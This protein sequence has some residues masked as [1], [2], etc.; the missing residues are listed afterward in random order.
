MSV[1]MSQ[2]IFDYATSE[3][4]QDAFIS[5][6]VCWFYNDDENLQRI[7]IDFITK[8]YDEYNL[9]YLASKLPILKIES[10]KLIQQH[11]KID[12]Y[13]EVTTTEGIEIP[14]IIED[15]TWT[16]P[17]S[18]QLQNYAK[19]IKDPSIK[20]FFKTGHITEKDKKLTNDTE[21]NKDG[22]P[23]AQYMIIDTKWIYD[24]LC[25]YK[26]E[27][28]DVIFISYLN[29]LKREFYNKLYTSSGRKKTL[30]DWIASDLKEGFVQY[31]LIK[32]IKDNINNP[33]QNFIKFTKNGKRWDTWWT[34]LPRKDETQ[35][36]V[37]ITNIKKKYRIRLIEYSTS[38]NKNIN[39]KICN[40]IIISLSNNNIES[41]PKPRYK[42]KETEIAYLEIMDDELKKYANNFAKFIQ[43]FINTI[44]KN[45]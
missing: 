42:A 38:N 43:I 29:Y 5:L 40:E 21:L 45:L 14:F 9:N 23:K 33:S 4:S 22:T 2:N 16:E 27:I 44:Q 39:W 37:K 18:N 28:T 3:L 11:Y 25:T 17:H 31:E 19:K 32:T 30:I 15:K 41:T 36:F 6:M 12:V 24:F 8:L 26:N 7:S 20:I 13:F 34:F 35:F 10:V 1:K